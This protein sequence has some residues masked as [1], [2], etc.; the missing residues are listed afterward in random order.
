GGWGGGGGGGWGGAG[1]GRGGGRAHYARPRQQLLGAYTQLEIART[2][3]AAGR[4]PQLVTAAFHDALERAEN[5][6]HTHLVRE[7]E[8]E[9]KAVDEEAYGQHVFARVRGR[10]APADTSSLTEGESEGATA[11]FLNLQE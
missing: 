7:V 6:R 2:M 11:L 9:L 1:G 3:N 5:C 10:T 4:V 8:E